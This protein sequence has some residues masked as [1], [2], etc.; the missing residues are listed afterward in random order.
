MMLLWFR[1]D[2]LVEQ[3]ALRLEM[4]RAKINKPVEEIAS[5][6]E[7]ATGMGLAGDSKWHLADG[8]ELLTTITDRHAKVPGL[9]ET[10]KALRESVGSDSL[11]EITAV[12]EK[13]RGQGL[14][15]PERASSRVA[16][17]FGTQHCVARSGSRRRRS[18]RLAW[19]LGCMTS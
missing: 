12:I 1:R 7:K 10:E 16:V 4:L 18:R 3:E 2:Q 15:K 6:I 9:L 14:D 5:V 13:A 8:A 19:Q 11:D 17:T